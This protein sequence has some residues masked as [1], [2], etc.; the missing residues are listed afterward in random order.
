MATL[1]FIWES[2]KNKTD[3]EDVWEA[4]ILLKLKIWRSILL[5]LKM[6]EY[7]IVHI[8]SI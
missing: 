8:Y 2:I 1:L 7:D 5:N 4:H 6:S 3:K